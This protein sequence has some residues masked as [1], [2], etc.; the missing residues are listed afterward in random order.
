MSCRRICRELLWLARFGELGPSSAPHLEHLAEC[1]GCRDEVGFDRALV[2]QLRTA[3]ASRVEGA[4]PSPSA[5]EAI[6]ERT[7]RSEP[8]ATTGIRTWSSGVVGRLRFATAMAGTGLAL[9]LALNMEVVPVIV[10]ADSVSAPAA[11]AAG[12]LQVPRLPVERGSEVQPTEAV[13]AAPSRDARRSDP[14]VAMTRVAARTAPPAQ[15]SNGTEEPRDERASG[16]IRVV[17][18]P[19]QSP[20]PV[21]APPSPT[22]AGPR[23]PVPAPRSQPGEPS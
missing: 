17:F 23:D 3:L 16:V 6:L 7:Q 2:R 9:V 10:P 19:L 22:V 14:E 5:W 13:A 12:L 20:D 8:H 1:R 11:E 18:R 21:G 4:T 15:A